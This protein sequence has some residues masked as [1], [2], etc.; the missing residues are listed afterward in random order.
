MA[1]TPTITVL[2]N[3]VAVLDRA[4]DHLFQD[5]GACLHATYTTVAEARAALAQQWLGSASRAVLV[6]LSDP[7]APGRA[8]AT[9]TLS[10]PRDQSVAMLA[11]IGIACGTTGAANDGSKVGAARADR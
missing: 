6:R 7:R 10:G 1:L 4:I 9:V 8:A 5:D 3:G 11:A 2:E